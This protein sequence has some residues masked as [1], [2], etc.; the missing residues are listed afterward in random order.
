MDVVLNQV[1]SDSVFQEADINIKL[2]DG[3][4]QPYMKYSYEY[5]ENSYRFDDSVFGI[6]YKEKLENFQ[7]D[8][9]IGKTSR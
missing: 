7:L 3:R 8:L 4:I 2:L 1:R 6:V 9:V 5:R